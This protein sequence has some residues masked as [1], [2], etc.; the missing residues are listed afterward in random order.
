VS[1]EIRPATSEPDFA[2]V[3]RLFEDYAGWIRIDLSFQNF[4][5]ELR[6]LPGEYAPPSGALFVAFAD[7]APAGCIAVR[8]F[9]EQRCEMKRLFVKDAYRGLGLG[10]QLAKRAIEWARGAGYPKMLLD[11]LPSM[12]E[13]QKL[14]ARLGFVEIPAYRFNPVAGARY[15]S[16][17]LQSKASSP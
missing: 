2:V 1:P 3:R 7:E 11:T 15:M 4:A 8:R 13:A 9:D 12:G 17:D 16:L 5:E 10:G 14:Y 6:L